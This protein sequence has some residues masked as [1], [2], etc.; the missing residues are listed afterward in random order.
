MTLKNNIQNVLKNSLWLIQERV[1]SMFLS[2]ATITMV[3]RVLGPEQFGLYSYCLSIVA[4]FSG[5]TILGWDRVVLKLLSEVEKDSKE[6]ISAQ[7]ALRTC[8]AVLAF[9]CSVA[10]AYFTDY[11][12]AITFKIVVLM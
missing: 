5:L 8:G 1:I 9:F 12:P 7:L 2:L 3:A 4:I 11:Q 6:I 10:Y